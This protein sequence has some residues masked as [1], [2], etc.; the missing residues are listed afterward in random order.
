MEAEGQGV[1]FTVVEG[2]WWL[3]LIIGTAEADRNVSGQ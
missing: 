3:E 1:F 2:Q